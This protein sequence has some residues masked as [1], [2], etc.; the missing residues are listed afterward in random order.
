MRYLDINVLVER[1]AREGYSWIGRQ[2]LRSR[3]KNNFSSELEWFRQFRD[4]RW[5]ALGEKKI[6]SIQTIFVWALF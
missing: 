6:K 4:H 3:Q 2:V 1:Q 5:K